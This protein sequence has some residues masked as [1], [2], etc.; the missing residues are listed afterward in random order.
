[1]TSRRRQLDTHGFRNVRSFRPRLGLSVIVKGFLEVLQKVGGGMVAIGSDRELL[2]PGPF[3]HPQLQGRFVDEVDVQVRN[4]LVGLLDLHHPLLVGGCQHL[5]LDVVVFESGAGVGIFIRIRLVVVVLA[6][7]S[8]CV[9]EKLHTGLADV[10]EPVVRG[11]D[12]V[13]LVLGFEAP[14]SL[15]AGADVFVREGAGIDPHHDLGQWSLGR[16]RHLETGH[17]IHEIPGNLSEVFIG[18]GFLSDVFFEIVRHVHVD[19]SKAKDEP[20]EI[21]IGKRCLRTA[22]GILGQLVQDALNVGTV[23]ISL[24]AQTLGTGC[25]VLV[26]L[27]LAWSFEDRIGVIIEKTKEFDEGISKE[28]GP[29]V[30]VAIVAMVV[31]SIGRWLLLVRSTIINIVVIICSAVPPC[32]DGRPIDV[33]P[34]TST[35]RSSSSRRFPVSSGTMGIGVGVGIAAR[36]GSLSILPLVTLTTVLV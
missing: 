31:V 1:M 25:L 22:T 12:R 27:D 8:Q 15:E 23:L 5:V 11:V 9:V 3:L 2:V 6:A 33:G 18:E 36:T 16:A 10:H 30:L 34:S 7:L 19:A 24:P 26:D 17:E 20:L 21:G 14:V 28:Y 35:S 4:V 13:H 29:D 32:F